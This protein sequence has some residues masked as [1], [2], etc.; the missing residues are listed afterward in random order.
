MPIT[1]STTDP[2]VGLSIFNESA[3]SESLNKLCNHSVSNINVPRFDAYTDVHDFMSDFERITA[4]LTADQKLLVLPK[5]FPANCYRSWYN[6]E[7]APL[8]KGQTPW[9]QVKNKILTRFSSLG[10]EDK[11]FSRLRELKYDPEGSQS[12]LGY[13]EDILYSYERAYPDDGVD[14]KLKYIKLSLPPSLKAKL[15][16][17]Q[18][19]KNASS[20][21]MLKSAAKDYDAAR[22][23]SPKR[24]KGNESTEELTN[25]IRELM[26]NVKKENQAIRA[27]NE[28]I[29]QEMTAAIRSQED[30][31]PRVQFQYNRSRSPAGD[32]VMYRQKSPNRDYNHPRNSFQG[33]TNN[34]TQYYRENSPGRRDYYQQPVNQPYVNRP[35]SPG[36]R[37]QS[38]SNYPPNSSR[39]YQNRPPTPYYGDN[40]AKLSAKNEVYDYKAYVDKFGEPPSPCPNCQGMHWMRHCLLHLN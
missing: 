2:L 26:A 28:A 12:L 31:Q 38:P 40:Q 11:H 1:N 4:A 25:L 9:V 17:Y 20:I 39:G 22:D 29:R 23:L 19:F 37:S 15:N 30:R 13:I 14:K 33:H 6:T 16:L 10:A 8:I 27:E 21:D 7:L 5:S 18:D 36:K 32:N 34:N 24:T 3:I 35:V